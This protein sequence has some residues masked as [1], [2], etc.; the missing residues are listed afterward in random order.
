MRHASCQH[1]AVHTTPPPFDVQIQLRLTQSV[2]AGAVLSAVLLGASGA[3]ARCPFTGGD[4]AALAAPGRRLQTSV[5][6]DS[7]PLAPYTARI[8]L[9]PLS[10]EAYD[11]IEGEIAATLRESQDFWPLDFDTYGPLMIRLAWH[12]SGTY[13]Q[14]DGRG[15]CDGGRI[16]FLP[17]YAWEDNTNLDKALALLRPLAEKYEG[18]ISWCA[19]RLCFLGVFFCA[20][21]PRSWRYAPCNPNLTCR[22]A[23]V[24]SSC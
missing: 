23:G 21:M 18:V 12:C 17:E 13:R 15:G 8:A 24:I 4:A 14:S 16:R 3:T 22:S 7:T 6:H 10:S 1:P 5:A 11:R 20:L 2:C 9:P 19:P